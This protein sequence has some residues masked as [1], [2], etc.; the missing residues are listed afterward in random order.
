MKHI[1]DVLNVIDIAQAKST[2]T[3]SRSINQLSA[4]LVDLL[5]VKMSILCRGYQEVFDD[6][7]KLN[8]E[9][10]QWTKAFSKRN[11]TCQVQI[12]GAIDMLE[13]HIY[14]KPPQLGQFLEWCKLLPTNHDF[15][16]PDVAFKVAGLINSIDSVY[17]HPHQP[18]DIVIR[19][20]LLQLGPSKFRAMKEEDALKLFEY[21]YIVVCRAYLAGEVKDIPK[22][23]SEK[24]K[25]H[26]I[27]KV[28]NDEARNKAMAVI[29]EMLK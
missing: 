4:K 27:D 25:S 22:A 15:L 2:K 5:F 8:A 18:T 6:F 9:K 19:N 14:P 17:I 1:F 13:E 23:I 24:P 11:I 7:K 16:K 12:Q 26:P 29:R 20:T 28:K 3:E 21:H 10:L